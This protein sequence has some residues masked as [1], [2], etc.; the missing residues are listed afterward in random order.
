MD[1]RPILLA[2]SVLALPGCA[3][4]DYGYAYC[5]DAYR[6]PVG[7]DYGPLEPKPACATQTAQAAYFVT[8]EGGYRGPY[9]SG[10]YSWPVA[11]GA[12]DAATPHGTLYPEQGP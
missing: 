7:H 2:L 11:P 10:P 3:S 5:Y 12:A 8:H 6:G 1:A 9:V 4:S